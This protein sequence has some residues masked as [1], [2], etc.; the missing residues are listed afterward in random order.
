MLILLGYFILI[1]TV[2]VNTAMYFTISHVILT[3]TLGAAIATMS[4]Q[5]AGQNKTDGSVLGIQRCWLCYLLFIN[6]SYIT[7]TT[8]DR[9]IY[10]KLFSCFKWSLMNY[11]VLTAPFDCLSFIIPTSTVTE[12][13]FYYYTLRWDIIHI[14]ST[15][16]LYLCY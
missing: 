16:V 3:N 6:Y 4:N 10:F 12:L 14:H 7:F 8:C 1:N 13:F 2:L 15:I 5:V 11:S 9:C